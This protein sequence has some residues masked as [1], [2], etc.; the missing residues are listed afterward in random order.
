MTIY[1]LVTSQAIAAYWNSFNEKTGTYLFESF[2]PARQQLGMELSYLKGAS[3]LPVALKVSALDVKAVP[4][5]R[6]GFS[7]I[8]GEM[9]FFKESLL[10][11][12]HDRQQ[13]NLVM[14]S[15]VQSYIDMVMNKIFADKANL[16]RG[17]KASRE[18]LRAQAVST[19][20]IELSS[21]GQVYSY[22]YQVPAAHKFTCPNFTDPDFDFIDYINECRKKIKTDTG[23][24]PTRG[25]F[26]DG[27]L[28][29]LAKN[30]LLRQKMYVLSQGIGTV[31]EKN[32]TDY[33]KSETGVTFVEYS[34]KFIDTDGTTKTFMPAWSISIFPDTQ[35]GET[36]FGTTPEQSDLMSGNAA[37]VEIVDTGVAVTAMKQD[38]PVTVETKVTMIVLPSLP[39][40][41]QIAIIDVTPGADCTL[42]G[43]AIGTLE[44]NPA[45][46]P[47]I[48]AYSLATSNASNKITAVANDDDATVVIKNGDTSVTSGAAATWT[49]GGNDVTITVTNDESEK[50]YNVT[51]MYNSAT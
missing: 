23:T 16:I 10:I 24:N 43:L 40:A 33:L 12:E 6:L 34:D 38:D 22:D 42:K 2:F 44:L 26:A 7:K 35:L 31:T 46:D 9:P 1:D 51:V 5:D 19:G 13:L 29:K 41:D 20:K 28:S 27:I 45:F 36:V 32:V 25:V 3:G 30:N 50:V 37:N 47:N 8:T 18:W 4:R 11:N 39:L 49:A 14:Q 48:T 17:A 15:G 21:N